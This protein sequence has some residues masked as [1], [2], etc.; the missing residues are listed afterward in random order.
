MGDWVQSLGWE[1]PLEKVK[2]THSSILAWR[3]PWTVE[4]MGSQ[5]V[6]YNRATFTSLRFFTSWAIREAQ[7]YWS[8]KPIPSPADFP[9]PEIEPGSPAL[10]ADSLTAEPPGK[11][12]AYWKNFWT[13]CRSPTPSGHNPGGFNTKLYLFPISLQ[14]LHASWGSPMTSGLGVSH[15]CCMCT[16]GCRPQLPWV[17]SLSQRLFL[18]NLPGTPVPP[19]QASAAS[20]PPLKSFSVPVTLRSYTSQLTDGPFRC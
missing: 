5:S 19:E 11:P 7:E 17:D 8:G 13:E 15:S 12:R 18:G 3:I 14:L 20:C 9:S 4:S 10:Q 6:G 16:A 2:A 1:D